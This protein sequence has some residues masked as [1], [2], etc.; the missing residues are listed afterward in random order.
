MQFKTDSNIEQKET[1][2]ID[3]KQSIPSPPII[4]HNDNDDPINDD[5]EKKEEP[6]QEQNDDNIHADINVINDDHEKKEE[7]K[8]EKSPK[9]PKP[10]KQEEEEV[11]E[12]EEVEELK[13]ME[14]V[15]MTSLKSLT[16]T[17]SMKFSQEIAADLL[18]D[19]SHDIEKLENI[20]KQSSAE[21]DESDNELSQD[22]DAEDGNDE[23]DDSSFSQDEFDLVD[24][25]QLQD[26]MT[27]RH[28]LKKFGLV[29]FGL[30]LFTYISFILYP[31]S[32]ILAQSKLHIMNYNFCAYTFE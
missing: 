23:D 24:S 4:N 5:H 1:T 31:L 14:T 8:E 29:W 22:T 13:E 16:T 21:D 10:Q 28:E 18:A 2:E 27:I 6:K 25:A 3:S 17:S 20:Q 19:I 9:S 15:R 11:E 26:M 32:F 30:A 12:V 7:Q